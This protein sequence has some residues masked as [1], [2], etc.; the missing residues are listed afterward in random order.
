MLWYR[1]VATLAKI[2]HLTELHFT[3]PTAVQITFSILWSAH[4]CPSTV[5]PDTCLCLV[6]I[7]GWFCFGQALSSTKAEHIRAGGRK[8]W[9]GCSEHHITPP[10]P[11]TDGRTPPQA[12]QKVFKCLSFHPNTLPQEEKHPQIPDTTL[13]SIHE[14]QEYVL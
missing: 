2:T 5:C 4:P 10:L 13:G 1:D 7:P 9:S 6:T 14:P 8:G 3:A 11:T 12:Q